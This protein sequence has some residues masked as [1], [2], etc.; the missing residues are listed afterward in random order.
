MALLNRDGT[1]Y[2]TSGK[3]RRDYDP[4]KPENCLFDLWDQE[5]IRM[6]GSPIYYYEVFIN[7]GMIDPL[8]REARGKI[9]S[10]N[11]IQLYAHYEPVPSQNVL[12][13]FGIDNSMDEMIFELNYKATL[14]TI[15][16]PPK[17]GSRIY[18]PHRGEDWRI[19]QRNLG[20]FKMWGTVGSN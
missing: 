20:K 6:G 18:S 2:T 10:N 12:N 5:A 16:H 19:E 17:V 8:Y 11:P 14:A 3:G 1:P 13:Q 15:G 7:V 9:Y 4:G